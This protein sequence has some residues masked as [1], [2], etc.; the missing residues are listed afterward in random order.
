MTA[1]ENVAALRRARDAWNRGSSTNT[2]NSTTRA[3][4]CTATRG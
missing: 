1:E 4:C 2:W 3:L